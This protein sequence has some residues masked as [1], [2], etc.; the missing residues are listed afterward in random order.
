MAGKSSIFRP[1]WTRGPPS[2][3]K[4]PAHV[5]PGKGRRVY[6]VARPKM[7]SWKRPLEKGIAR[8]VMATLR[9]IDSNVD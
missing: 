5:S 3:R 4:D 7:R 8:P 2:V 6:A 9:D 1:T